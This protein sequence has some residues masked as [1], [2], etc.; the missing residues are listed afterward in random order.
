MKRTCNTF[1]LDGHFVSC[2]HNVSGNNNFGDNLGEITLEDA[3]LHQFFGFR[4]RLQS[5]VEFILSTC[6]LMLLAA[7]MGPCGSHL[8]LRSF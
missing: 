3:F 4:T 8:K 7:D 2:V 6:K 1:I 5:V